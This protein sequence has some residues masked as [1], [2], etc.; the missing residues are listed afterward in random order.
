[1]YIST[2]GW[3]GKHHKKFRLDLN[4]AEKRYL[5]ISEKV[6][7]IGSFMALKFWLYWNGQANEPFFKFTQM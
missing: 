5:M 6:L 1:M 3:G 7:V 4:P 2:D